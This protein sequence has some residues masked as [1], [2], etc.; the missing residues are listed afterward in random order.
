MKKLNEAGSRYLFIQQDFPEFN[1]IASEEKAKMK[2]GKEIST[3]LTE[4]KGF[5]SATEFQIRDP[6]VV[7]ILHSK[8]F[9][10]DQSI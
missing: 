5:H 4:V 6:M 3:T 9:L 8:Y 1:S 10:W 7:E 2:P